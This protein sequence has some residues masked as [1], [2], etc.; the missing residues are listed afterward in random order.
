[1][2]GPLVYLQYLLIWTESSCIRWH[3]LFRQIQNWP[4]S[5][6]SVFWQDEIITSRPI[7]GGMKPE[8]PQYE[9]RRPWGRGAI[10]VPSQRNK[11]KTR[12]LNGFLQEQWGVKDVRFHEEWR[13]KYCMGKDGQYFSNSYSMTPVWCDALTTFFFFFF[14]YSY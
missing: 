7:R 14:L 9:N 10:S 4:V 2:W 1:M 6:P 5:Q 3:I 8:R 12:S 11:H 13:M